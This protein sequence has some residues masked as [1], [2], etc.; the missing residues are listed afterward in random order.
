MLAIILEIEVIELF[1]RTYFVVLIPL[2]EKNEGWQMP[3]AVS[4]DA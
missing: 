3:V 2:S 1:I 4:F